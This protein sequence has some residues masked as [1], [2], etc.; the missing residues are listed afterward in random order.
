MT[1]HGVRWLQVPCGCA[2]ACGGL[3][4]EK[5]PCGRVRDASLQAGR[6]QRG[7]R[8]AQVRRGAAL[9][10]DSLR[11]LRL[12]SPGAPVVYLCAAVHQCIVSASVIFGQF[13]LQFQCQSDRGPKLSL[14]ISYSLARG[15]GVR[16]R[17]GARVSSPSPDPDDSD[18]YILLL[19]IVLL[20]M[21]VTVD[22]GRSDGP[23]G[24]RGARRR[25]S[26]GPSLSLSLSLQ[27]KFKTYKT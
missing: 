15:L 11:R 5:V 21:E 10:A 20:R 13:Q 2:R 8:Q 27:S 14:L 12:R 9:R 22:S 19:Q 26:P 3:Y 17:P 16:L 23:G 6:D 1:R 7:V 18:Q 4:G 24:P 25:P